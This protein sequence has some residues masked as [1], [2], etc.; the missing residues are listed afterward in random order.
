MHCPDQEY[1]MA[2]ASGV[3]KPEESS[4]CLDHL[5]ECELCR[6][7]LQ[8][9]RGMI[10]AI[11]RRSNPTLTRDE[12][13]QIRKNVMA[14]LHRCNSEAPLRRR[15]TRF[16]V[17]QWIIPVL[18][19]GVGLYSGKMLFQSN[20]PGA[21][22][23]AHGLAQYWSNMEILLLDWSNSDIS[24]LDALAI[25]DYVAEMKK[26]LM[27]TRRMREEAGQLS[28]RELLLEIEYLITG[29]L[30]EA[31]YSPL[32][33]MRRFQKQIRAGAYLDR[34]RHSQLW[35]AGKE[36]YDVQT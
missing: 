1:W 4:A 30:E 33:A 34:I 23:A 16:A 36:H 3:L 22:A 20:A 10:E 29:A 19:F 15:M 17:L 31:N 2:Y 6:V 13:V 25:K 28:D 27:T 26:T 32:A 8:S 5:D 9:A 7:E 18:I 11:E 14:E 24:Q 21:Q 12:A 35:G